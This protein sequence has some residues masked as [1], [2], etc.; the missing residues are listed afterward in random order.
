MSHLGK[1]MIIIV[2][3]TEYM[4]RICTNPNCY[5]HPIKVII[6]GNRAIKVTMSVVSN[7]TNKI[8]TTIVIIIILLSFSAA[9]EAPIAISRQSSSYAHLQLSSQKLS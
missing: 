7:F 5:S 6:N 8:I 4:K 1:K 3:K 9:A 2:F